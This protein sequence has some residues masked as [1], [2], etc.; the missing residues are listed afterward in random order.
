M[1]K[2]EDPQERQDF[3]EQLLPNLMQ[4]V[5]KV[6]LRFTYISDSKRERL[7]PGGFLANSK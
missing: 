5:I 3:Q 4:E 6:L 2:K 7:V 1:D